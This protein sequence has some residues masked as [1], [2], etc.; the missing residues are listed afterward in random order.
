[1]RL[2]LNNKYAKSSNNEMGITLFRGVIWRSYGSG[3]TRFGEFLQSLHHIFLTLLSSGKC[4]SSQG[5]FE[6]L[7]HIY[8]IHSI[9]T[10]GQTNLMEGRLRGE[11][12]HPDFSLWHNSEVHTTI[13]Q[14]AWICYFTW[15]DKSSIPPI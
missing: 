10:T 6:L 4:Y 5:I 12:V 11:D 13:L 14:N 1:M 7:F 8:V 3:L 2:I 15:K 9:N